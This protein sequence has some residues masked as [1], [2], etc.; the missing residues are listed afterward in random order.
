[1]NVYKMRT[2]PGKQFVEEE[3]DDEDDDVDFAN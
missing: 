3:D 2:R 1:M